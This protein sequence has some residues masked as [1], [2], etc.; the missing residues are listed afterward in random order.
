[1]SRKKGR[2]AKSD[3]VAISKRLRQFIR[4]FESQSKFAQ[5]FHIPRSTL[6]SWTNNTAPAV[7]EPAY[8]IE[9]AGEGN[10]SLNWLL[11]GEGPELTERKTTTAKGAFMAAIAARLQAT[12]LSPGADHDQAWARLAQ[13]G[14]DAVFELAVAAVR[15]LYQQA[16]SDLDYARA[17]AHN[18]K[19]VYKALLMEAGRDVGDEK[20]KERVLELGTKV[21]AALLTVPPRP[22]VFH[23]LNLEPTESPPQKG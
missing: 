12:E 9:M 16:L 11:L 15:P 5:R 4:R 18:L 2:L 22:M 10:L 1:M 3:A 8:L 17:N 13:Y 19:Q 7:P 14:P 6:R 20:V 23:P 21:V